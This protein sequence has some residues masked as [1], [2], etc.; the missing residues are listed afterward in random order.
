MPGPLGQLRWSL[1]LAPSTSPAP[2]SRLKGQGQGSQKAKKVT[3]TFCLLP[4]SP[5]PPV[6][7]RT[8]ESINFCERQ[9]MAK[10]SRTVCSQYPCTYALCRPQLRARPTP[11]QSPMREHH[12]QSIASRWRI[13]ADKHESTGMYKI[14]PLARLGS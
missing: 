2:L 14:L 5:L 13:G 4:P 11:Y 6:P 8:H 1:L 12:D 9:S 10:A 7:A 3:G